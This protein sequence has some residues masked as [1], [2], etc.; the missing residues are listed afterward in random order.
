MQL[1]HSSASVVTRISGPFVSI[2]IGMAL[3]TRCTVSTMRDAPSS[4]TWAELI[5]TTSI[6]ASDSSR[7]NSSVQRKSDIVATIFVFFI[8]YIKLTFFRFSIA[9]VVPRRAPVGC[10][11]GQRPQR[12]RPG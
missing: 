12:S 5:R 8:L 9:S 7:T 4:V 10:L 6:P 11:P 2:M 1:P 3:F